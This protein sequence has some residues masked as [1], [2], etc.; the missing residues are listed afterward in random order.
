MTDKQ[1]LERINTLLD[2]YD[3]RLTECEWQERQPARTA[4]SPTYLQGQREMLSLICVDL[5]SL[6][7]EWGKP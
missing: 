2:K 5:E 7:I 3:A 4:P 1:L 6:I